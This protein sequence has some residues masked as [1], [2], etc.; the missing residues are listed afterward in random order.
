MLQSFLFKIK[1]RR[2]KQGR[3]Y[4]QGYILLFS[5]FAILSGA[6]SY[7]KIQ[8]FIKT[9]YKTLDEIFDLN[10]K[11][12][13][14]YTTIRAII[15]G[16]ASAEVE[17]QFRQYSDWLAN[18]AE[19]KRFV[20]FDGKVLRGSFDHFQDQKAIQILSA[21]VTD[22]RIV[23]AHAEIAEKTNEIPT[24]RELIVSLGLSGCIFTFDALHC[25]VKTLEVAKATGNEVI[26]QVK[27][28][29]QTLFHDCQTTTDTR[30]PDAVYQ[31]P[32]TKAH[33][34]IESRRVK[35]FTDLVLRD[36]DKWHLVAAMVKVER[37]RRVLDTKTKRWQESDETAFYIATSVLD[38]EV[39]CQAI[40]RHWDIENGNHH[41]RDVTLGEDR[42]RIRDNP[43]LFAKLRSFAL[44]I[45][46]ANNVKN[47]SVEL[48]ENCMDLNRVLNYVGVG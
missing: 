46:R 25:Q 45:L 5:I 11:R 7:R 32:L 40:R 24:A 15:R 42:S 4:Q 44:N 9:H 27:E 31:E 48:F 35:V 43:H 30:Q 36:S 47:V 33:N 41:V 18:S 14:A 19:G 34:R 13:P 17:E 23:L 6:D 28:N 10:W 21:F 2:R 38:A 29:Q 16:A 1:D 26:V 22:S 20:A 3:R 39:F 8:A 12:M 37:R